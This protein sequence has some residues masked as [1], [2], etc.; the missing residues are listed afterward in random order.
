[1][2]EAVGA[3]PERVRPVGTDR[4]P[5]ARAAAGVLGAVGPAVRGRGTDPA[6]AVAGRA[7]CGARFE[8]T[9]PR[10]VTLYA[11]SDDTDLW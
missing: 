3:D 11:V 6:A 5:A 9:A 1:M 2:F 8:A 10:A 4:H 7:G